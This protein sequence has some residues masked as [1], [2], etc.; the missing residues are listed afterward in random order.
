MFIYTLK[1]TYEKIQNQCKQVIV[2]TI[3]ENEN[4]LNELE[5]FTIQT[6]RICIVLT[7]M[8]QYNQN[9]IDFSLLG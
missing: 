9:I 6:I 3:T 8:Y 2:Q 4:K 7:V 1:Y 5:I